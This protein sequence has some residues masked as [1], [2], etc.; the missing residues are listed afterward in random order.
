M[1]FR[2]TRTRTVADSARAEG[3]NLGRQKHVGTW[4]RAGKGKERGQGLQDLVCSYL[5][6]EQGAPAEQEPRTW[7]RRRALPPQLCS[8]SSWSSLRGGGLGSIL[9]PSP[10]GGAVAHPV[11]ATTIL[12]FLGFTASVRGTVPWRPLRLL[13]WPHGSVWEEAPARSLQASA[14]VTSLQAQVPEGE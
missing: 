4:G 8:H 1:W 6:S 7:C 10:R 3:H 2:G 5:C 12:N 13:P 11:P 14:Q 9:L